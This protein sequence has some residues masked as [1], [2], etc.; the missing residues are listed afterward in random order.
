[1]SDTFLPVTRSSI[2]PAPPTAPPGPQSCW[3]WHHSAPCAPAKSPVSQ[4]N[5]VFKQKA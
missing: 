5:P 1:M 4:G 3:A 2:W